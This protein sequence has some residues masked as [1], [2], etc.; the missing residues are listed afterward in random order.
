[1]SLRRYLMV[2]AGTATDLLRQPISLILLLGS[3]GFMGLIANVYYIGFGD[4]GRLVKNSILALILL[5]GLFSSV[6][7]A[8]STLAKEIRGGT[9]LAVLAKPVSR[10]GFLLAKFSGLVL[11]LGA[12]VAIQLISALT[13]SRLAP[14]SQQESNSPEFT[15]YFLALLAAPMAGAAVNYFAQRHFISSS[16]LALAVSATG[17]FSLTSFMSPDGQTE[18]FWNRTDW[19]MLQAGVLIWLAILVLAAGALACSTRLDTLPTL[20]L[21]LSIFVFGLMSDYLFGRAAQQGSTLANLCYSLVP[22]W[23]LFWTGDALGAEKTIPWS[24]VAKT[25]SYAAGWVIGLLSI[26]V[27]LFQDRDLTR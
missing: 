16:I 15:L 24:Y 4:D 14:S 27:W 7:S 8:S 20:G 10:S 9:A 26:G 6:T 12:Q 3:L 5:T 22:N 11:A 13:V 19:R 23:Q 25:S 21:C 18:T 1:M 17:I 2:A